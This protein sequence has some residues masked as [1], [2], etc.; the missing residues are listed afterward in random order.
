MQG[1]LFVRCLKPNNNSRKSEFD[2]IV[3]L[4][5]LKSACMFEY[6]TLEKKGFPIRIEYTNLLTKYDIS[7]INLKRNLKDKI[8]I[9][10]RSIGLERIGFKIGN[11]QIFFRSLK[12]QQL[13]QIL[14]PTTEEINNVKEIFE[15]KQA[16]IGRWRKFMKHISSVSEE[17]KKSSR[18]TVYVENCKNYFLIIHSRIFK[19]LVVSSVFNLF[20]LLNL[21]NFSHQPQT[22]FRT[23]DHLIGQLKSVTKQENKKHRNLFPF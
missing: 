1:N 23:L 11:T 19:Y 2:S 16:V 7:T 6:L 13:N 8:D 10:L 5:Q 17:T 18:D 21:P 22:Q 3:V 20:Q 14:N 12:S 4:E 15:K 9:L